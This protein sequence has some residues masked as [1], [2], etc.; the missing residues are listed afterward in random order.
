[1]CGDG[2]ADYDSSDFKQLPMISGNEQ[3]YNEPNINEGKKDFLEF[4]N[5]VDGLKTK[6]NGR[7]GQMFRAYDESDSDCS[8]DQDA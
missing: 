7:A 3:D 5:F 4:A 6:N 2:D 1:M 8:S